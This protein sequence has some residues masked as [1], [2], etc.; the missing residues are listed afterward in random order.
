MIFSVS[1]A[2]YDFGKRPVILVQNFFGFGGASVGRRS[3]FKQTDYS[4]NFGG[5]VLQFC[6]IQTMIHRI[7]M[8]SD[9][10][11]RNLTLFQGEGGAPG[12]GWVRPGLLALAWPA[13]VWIL[14]R[15]V[16]ALA[17]VD[18]AWP[19]PGLARP[20]LAWSRPWLGLVWS[21]SWPWSWPGLAWPG[22]A[23][24]GLPWPDL[25]WSGLAWVGP[26]LPR[27]V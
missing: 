25:C 8:V 18:L 5:T 23:S 2:P 3:N 26:V 1:A 9:I 19:W 6:W 21:W 4:F 16:L 12:S 10:D 13:L 14:V 15:P 27:L 20:G 24:S 22:L 11:P 17:W 7:P